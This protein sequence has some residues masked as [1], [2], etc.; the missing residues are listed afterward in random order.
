[1][2]H[3]IVAFCSGS[4]SIGNVSRNVRVRESSAKV[5]WLIFCTQFAVFIP[6]NVKRMKIHNIMSVNALEASC[7]WIEL[8]KLMDT[9]D[10]PHTLSLALIPFRQ[11]KFFFNRLTRHCAENILIR[12]W[13][14]Q[15]TLWLEINVEHWLNSICLRF[16]INYIL[17][18]D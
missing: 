7:H 15:F 2:K 6:T 3:A 14:A 17:N 13:W 12:S 1:M 5:Q 9:Q 10:L 18:R 16:S 8:I 11:R 4:Q